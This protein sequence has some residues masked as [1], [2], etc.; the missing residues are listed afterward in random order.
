MIPCLR[1]VYSR[2]EL[3]RLV[4]AEEPHE[5]PFVYNHSKFTSQNS[6]RNTLYACTLFRSKT[7]Y[8]LQY[9]AIYF[10]RMPQAHISFTGGISSGRPVRRAGARDA[11]DSFSLPVHGTRSRL[12]ELSQP[13]HTSREACCVAA[14]YAREP[15]LNCH[16]ARA[17]QPAPWLPPAG[18]PCARW[19]SGRKPR[20]WL[21]STG[22]L[23]IEQRPAEYMKPPQ[24][25]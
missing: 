7:L 8:T 23:A 5:N 22:W 4:K 2:P 13:P 15:L 11:H 12:K 1:F 21:T 6:N 18:P 24:R 25:P 10:T 16:P 20:R 9:Q 17:C 14:S 3:V 19:A